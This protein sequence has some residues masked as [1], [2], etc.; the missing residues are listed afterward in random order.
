MSKHLRPVRQTGLDQPSAEAGPV[1]PFNG[2]ILYILTEFTDQA[3]ETTEASWAS[4]IA[5]NID[6]FYNTA[7]YGDVTLSP[8]NETYG[9]ANNGVV[10]WV[11]VGYAHPNTSGSTGT[12][13]RQLTRDA[14]LEADPYVNFAAYDANSDGYVDSDELAVVIIAAGY[15][16]ALGGHPSPSVWGHKWSVGGSV[17]APVV[18]GVTVGAYNGGNGGYAQFGELHQ[19]STPPHW[20]ATMGIQVHELGHL[21]FG[22]PDLYDTDGTSD[23]VSRWCVM[24]G[25][26]W[27]SSNT[28]AHG[29]ETPVLP[30]AWI[31]YNQG[32]V[33]GAEGNGTESMTA[34]GDAVANGSNTVFKASTCNTPDEYFLVEN[35][36]PLGYD[37]GLERWMGASFGG[38]AIFHVDD[39]QTSNSNDSHRWVDVEEGDG[40]ADGPGQTTDLW[41]QGHAVTFNEASIPN[42]EQYNGSQSNVAITNITPAGTVMTADFASCLASPPAAP[43]NLTVTLYQPATIELAWTDNATNEDG[44]KLERKEDDGEFVEI[45][46]LA[47]NVTVFNDTYVPEIVYTYRIRAYNTSGHSDYSNEASLPTQQPLAAPTALSASTT[48]STTIELT[49]MDNATDETGFKLERKQGGGAFA[50][51][52]TLVA[53]YTT[54]ID[55][56]LTENTSYTYRIRAFNDGG[57]SDYSAELQVITDSGLDP[58]TNIALNQPVA[59]GSQIPS[60]PKENAVDGSAS[61][62][63]GGEK[64]GNNW[65]RVDVG[66]GQTVGRAVIKWAGGYHATAYEL[67][68]SDDAA[69]WT[70]V[71]TTTSGAGGDE[72]ITFAQSMARYVR[73]YMTAG[74]HSTYIGVMEL[75]V[76][77][78]GGST[79]TPTAPSGLAATANG[80]SVDLTWTDN[81]NDEAGFRIERKKA[82]G[83][84][85][86]VG[87]AVA[88]ATSYSDLGL[89]A[90][91]TYTYRVRAYNGAGN[92]NASN[93]SSATTA[94]AQQP[95]AAPSALSVTDA[96]NTEI[97][98]SWT[99][100]ASDEDGF[101]IERKTGAGTFAEIATVGADMTSHTDTGLSPSTTYSY[102]VR[103]YN[104]G[105]NSAY[106]NEASGAT[107]NTNQNLALNKPVS[108]SGTYPGTAAVNIIDGDIGTYWGVASGGNPNQ[109]VRIDLEVAETVGR[110]VIEWNAPYFA[111]GYEIQ[112][113]DD[114]AN[115]TSVYSTSSG[116]GGNDE[117]TFTQ[118]SARY[119]RLYMTSQNNP[120]GYSLFEMEIYSGPASAALAKDSGED[121][122]GTAVIP[123]GFALHQN[124]PNPFNPQTTISFSLP[125]KAHVAIKIFD[126]TGKEVAIL[127]GKVYSAGAHSIAFEPKGLP[128]GV[129]MYVMKAGNYRESK[130]ML[131]LK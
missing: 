41:Y 20:Q 13:N 104:S 63:W 19:F 22:M 129:Y 84:F 87:V 34:A 77:H 53:D 50:E 107:T 3:G 73:L 111:D 105:G 93:E 27:G 69:S 12:P 52:A 80:A 94:Q 23:G 38:L 76:Y 65:L 26:S 25:G 43:S 113:S 95:P 116:N 103:A 42:S 61:T 15:E 66:A 11:N 74:V 101:K 2:A 21:I 83:V 39:S 82:S 55:V 31:K 131:Y 62:A 124:Y 98:L 57:N 48:G 8:S 122:L 91:T 37:R 102:R 45:G 4:F 89:E 47:A 130:R 125:E 5:N 46:I 100:N 32:W 114:D 14:I 108:V 30:C 67:Q 92:S 18:D 128:S 121:I 78:G 79:T 110:V 1:G 33:D 59:V 10:G 29:G 58:N 126:I 51:I 96:R 115:W 86:E 118:T 119:V 60:Y 24:S 120:G 97:D 44:F 70:T 49:W 85:M 16:A 106:S 35:R 28:D 7:S 117:F 109:W 88:G 123:D 127:G 40:D 112:V 99:D 56:G 75:E 17:A 64:A 6:D 81:A 68:L 36:R 72:E 90:F 54:Y 9:V 71:H